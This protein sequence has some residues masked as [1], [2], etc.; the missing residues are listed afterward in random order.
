M[1][2]D[3]FAMLFDLEVCA[4]GEKCANCG[5]KGLTVRHEH[6]VPTKA[7]GSVVTCE[8]WL[9]CPRCTLDQVRT[10][11]FVNPKFAY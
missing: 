7:S 9:T 11:Q 10:F 6:S 8:P 2:I 3:T 5:K 4:A 1:T